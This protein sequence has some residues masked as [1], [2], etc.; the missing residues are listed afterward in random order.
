MLFSNLGYVILELI[1]LTFVANDFLGSFIF[2]F[3][4][5]YVWFILYIYLSLFN[6]YYFNGTNLED[7]NLLKVLVIYFYLPEPII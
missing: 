6:S 2:S 4:N 3:K 7:F 5:V 1:F